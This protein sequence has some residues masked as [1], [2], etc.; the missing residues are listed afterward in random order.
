MSECKL[1]SPIEIHTLRHFPLQGK[2]PPLEILTSKM[3]QGWTKQIF[4]FGDP[5]INEVMTA[6]RINENCKREI[7]EETLDP[8]GLWGGD[9]D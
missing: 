7:F 3:E 6:T 8:H 2:V 4:L 1:Q 5:G 9:S